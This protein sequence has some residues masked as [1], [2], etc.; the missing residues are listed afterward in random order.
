MSKDRNGKLIL[1]TGN[2]A[3]AEGAIA[4]GCRFFGGY[5]I[6]PSSE[7][8]AYMSRRLPQVGGKFIQMEDELASIVAVVGASF[9]GAKAMTATSGPGFSLMAETV[10]LGVMLEAPLVIVT[11]MRGGPSTGQPTKASQ[12]DVMQVRFA[13]HG[14]YEVIV[15]TPAS[16]QEMYDFGIYAFNLAEKYRT[17]VI[18]AS[19]G[20]VGQMMEPVR[21]HTDFEIINRKGP[22]V[23]P[24]DYQPFEVFDEDLVP[25]MATAGSD[26]NFYVTGLTHDITGTPDMTPEAAISLVKRLCD[27]IRI[28]QS[29]INKY[30]PWEE[31]H[32]EDAETVILSYGINSRSVPEAVERA[33]KEG[34]KVGLVRLRTLWPFPEDLMKRLGSLGVKKII[35][36]EMN[37]GMV[38]REV[39]RFRHLG[40]EVT[41]ILIPTTIPFSP[42][43]IYKELLKE[44]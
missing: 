34:H 10:G 21:Y 6:T 5:P 8:A 26:Y 40:F 12:S 23:P 2:Y 4:A 37:Y 11:I 43:F 30:V 28:A 25:G 35:V 19:D 7:I 13:S 41:G 24:E 15:L 16:V 18:V 32:L 31:Q 1:T 14:D 22:Q 3:V 38:I 39:E 29:D 33:R 42:T 9:A 36:S 20:I 17:P 44:V 27:K